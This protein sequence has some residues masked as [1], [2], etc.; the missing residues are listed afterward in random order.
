MSTL[1]D[2]QTKSNSVV[3]ERSTVSEQQP[4]AMPQ[5]TSDAS[6]AAEKREQMIAVAAYFRA[7]RRG[8]CPGFELDD[9]LAA[10]ADVDWQKQ[11]SDASDAS[12]GT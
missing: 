8:F 5:G 11:S 1:M 2:K 4:P 6:A 10:E 9:W 7:E 12:L 3:L